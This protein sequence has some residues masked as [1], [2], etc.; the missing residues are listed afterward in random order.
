MCDSA[1]KA[2][3]DVLLLSPTPLSDSEQNDQ[4]LEFCRA[5]S[6]VAAEK[7][8]AFLNMHFQ[9]VDY[10]VKKAV[11]PDLFLPDGIHF[12]DAQYQV[13]AEELMEFVESI[14]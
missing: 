6:E 5:M 12:A 1:G 13:L 7:D 8:L 11:N 14:E 4:L 10:L 9:I 3:I 2:S